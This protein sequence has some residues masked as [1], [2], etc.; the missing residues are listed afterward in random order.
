MAA[1][2]PV[3]G[4]SP[5]PGPGFVQGPG[6][7]PGEEHG[8]SDAGGGQDASDDQ[9]DRRQQGRRARCAGQ[10]GIPGIIGIHQ[11]GELVP[12]ARVLV[13]RPGPRVPH[14]PST[15]AARVTW[16]S[17]VHEIEVSLVWCLPE[18]ELVLDWCSKFCTL[19][20]TACRRTPCACTKPDRAA[21]ERV[22]RD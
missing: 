20:I 15:P 22:P 3:P 2:R 13:F 4:N 14:C 12:G 11:H 19:T 21:D 16:T 5:E 7:L 9:E 8:Q 10:L 1:E 17:A 18:P 6:S